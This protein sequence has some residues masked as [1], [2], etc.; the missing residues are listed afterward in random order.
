MRIHEVAKVLICA[1]L[2]LAISLVG[3]LC[4]QT[5]AVA[6]PPATISLATAPTT[7]A[8][9]RV[10]R[11]VRF[12]ID[13]R[14]E[15]AAGRFEPKADGVGVRGAAPPLSW[16][17][18]MLAAPEGD[19]RY[20]VNI[21]FDR[22]EN[23]GQPLQ[24]KFR[25]ERPGLG[26]DAGW[27]DGR[28]RTLLL[29]VP[30]QTV[31]R[32]FNSPPEPVPRERTGHIDRIAPLPSRFVAPR[33]VQ[34]WLPP[35]Y[36]QEAA[37]RY[38]VLYL[39]DGQ[40]MFDAEAAGAE[41]QFDESAQRLVLSGA[42]EPFIIVAVSNTGARMDEYT[43][44]RALLPAART[45]LTEARHIGGSAPK[46]AD[47]LLK[48][49]KPLIDRRYR[50]R[51]DA[52]ST[53][54]GGSSIA[55]LLTLWLVLHHH[56]VFGA[57]LVVS[58]SVW[59]DDQFALR[60]AATAQLPASSQPKVWLDIGT[61]EGAEALPVMRKLRDTLTGRGWNANTLSYG[62]FADATHDEASWA[63][64]VEGMLRFLYGKPAGN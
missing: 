40:T 47:Y 60:D 63:L 21:A 54:T 50:T 44:T 15:I 38:P 46:Y 7:A 55:G 29:R 19:G 13:M 22:P 16:S 49:L 27:E 9:A 24:Y 59:W 4:A 35:G 64:R 32:A 12:V 5:A 36:E 28:N 14:A 41:W 42:I 34:V 48:E 56:D 20:A 3:S 26:P 33:E 39:H 62:E 11:S 31:T 43:P 8:A 58:P 52:T 18:S 2:E 30:A 57:G 45:G 10:S 51:P 6:N 1:L 61:L 53:A 25:I 37:R 17:Q 23:G